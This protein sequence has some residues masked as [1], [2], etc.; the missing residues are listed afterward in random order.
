MSQETKIVYQP[1]T[2]IHNAD[3]INI[4]FH[5]NTSMADDIVHVIVCQGDNDKVL[6]N[7]FLTKDNIHHLSKTITG[8]TTYK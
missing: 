8:T 7:I 4:Y 2:H 3:N 1:Y 5:F 6:A